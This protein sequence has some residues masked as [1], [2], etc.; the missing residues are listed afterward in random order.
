MTEWVDVCPYE[1]I[2]PDTGVCALIDGHQVA[3]IRLGDGTLYAISNFDPF[4]RANVL[5]RGI[6]GDKGGKPKI[7]SPVYKQNFD[8]R[9]GQ[10]YDDAS[11]RLPVYAVRRRNGRVEVYARPVDPDQAPLDDTTLDG[12]GLSRA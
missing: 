11:V 4:S 5:S 7:A 10:S 3:V 9:T 2:Y 8:L 6:V 1:E 12:A